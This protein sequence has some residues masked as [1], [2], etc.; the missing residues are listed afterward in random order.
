MFSANKR[1]SSGSFF[2]QNLTTF[3]NLQQQ[4]IKLSHK[5]GQKPKTK[6]AEGNQ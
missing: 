6:A 3:E 5:M 2:L 1:L 4:K